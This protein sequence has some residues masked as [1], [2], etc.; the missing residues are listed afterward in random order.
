MKST[1]KWLGYLL[2]L[3]GF[4]LFVLVISNFP[5]GYWSQGIAEIRWYKLDGL[6]IKYGNLVPKYIQLG[7][8]EPTSEELT[9]LAIKLDPAFF[10]GCPVNVMI[11]VNDYTNFPKGI[12]F[13]NYLYLNGDENIAPLLSFKLIPNPPHSRYGYIGAIASMV[14][15]LIL[16]IIGRGKTK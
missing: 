3:T 6:E 15:G 16:V 10:T 4:L 8:G 1:V 2:I 12:Q 9:Q 14:I 7:E 11:N 5:S 13:V